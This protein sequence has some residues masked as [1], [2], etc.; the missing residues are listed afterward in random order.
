MDITAATEAELITELTGRAAF[1]GIV[2]NVVLGTGGTPDVA[3][4]YFATSLAAVP[5]FRRFEFLT[6][7]KENAECLNPS[8]SLS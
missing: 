4:P 8:P 2:V 1:K 7:A 6:M 3:Y 5:N